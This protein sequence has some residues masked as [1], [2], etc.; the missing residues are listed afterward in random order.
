M[1]TTHFSGPIRV[2]G[3]TPISPVIWEDDFLYGASGEVAIPADGSE[4]HG[5]PW[6]SVTVGSATVA[7]LG[8]AQNGQVELA[9]DSTG[10]AQDAVLHQGDQRKFDVS[11][12]LQ[13]MFRAKL[14]ALPT[15][16]TTLVMGMANN[17]NLDKDTVAAAAWFRCQ[18][19][20][21]VVAESDD[22]TNDNDDVATG[23]TME[24]DTWYTFR[25][26]FTDLSDVKFYIDENQVAGG[27]TFDMSNLTAAESLMQPYFSLDKA[28]GTS[29][30]TLVIDYVRI[31]SERS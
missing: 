12:D 11:L 20:A 23:I 8:N 18:G 22:T 15:S 10:E 4:E 13:M 19:D 5:I 28:S 21:D 30:G 1:G 6:C 7:L 14:T 17:H 9:T 29:V 25:I 31:W 3:C 27:T 24:V 2:D 16:G 26:D